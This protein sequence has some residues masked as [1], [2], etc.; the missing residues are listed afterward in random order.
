VAPGLIRSH[1]AA[2]DAIPTPSGRS[3]QLAR[4]LLCMADLDE[5]QTD[6][7]P[8][9]AV[10]ALHVSEPAACICARCGNYA[11]Q[12]CSVV[13]ASQYLCR[14]CFDRERTPKR[15]HYGE[16]SKGQRFLNAL[17][18][19]FIGCP[20]IMVPCA[21]LL[22]SSGVNWPP[23]YWRWL[24]ILLYYIVLEGV[25]GQTLGKFLTN[26][27]VVAADGGVPTWRQIIVRSFVRLVPLEPLSFL[28]GDRGWH[29]TW[30]GTRVV[31]IRR[32]KWMISD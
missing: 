25:S 1:Q 6:Q 10:C 2:P 19:V 17:L 7:I 29:D 27:I 18:D 9:G 4:N 30:S 15:H 14:V 8:S 22:G 26:T 16:A 32:P 3:R 12:L 11:C 24:V 31:S 5:P 28:W 13:T 23:Q 21:V 20:L